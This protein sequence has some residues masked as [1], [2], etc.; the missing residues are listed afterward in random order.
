[1]IWPEMNVRWAY[2]LKQMFPNQYETKKLKSWKSSINKWND[3]VLKVNYV[4]NPLGLRA[5]AGPDSSIPLDI[6]NAVYRA[7]WRQSFSLSDDIY[8]ATIEDTLRDAMDVYGGFKIFGNA[9]K[10]KQ[11]T[12]DEKKNK[13]EEERTS[14]LQTETDDTF[15]N[16]LFGIVDDDRE[17]ELEE[18]KAEIEEQNAEEI[19]E[20]VA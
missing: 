18:Q 8:F 1:M 12:D 20:K 4:T 6:E 11:W 7:L 9:K 15:L 5:R 17:D 2:L 19:E 10:M 16:Q 3:K 14:E 13:E